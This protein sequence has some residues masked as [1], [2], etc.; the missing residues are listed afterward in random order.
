MI[1]IDE[2]PRI[3]TTPINQPASD[4]V[5]FTEW[6]TLINNMARI[7]LNQLQAY[8]L[9]RRFDKKYLVTEKALLSILAETISSYSVL[10]VEKS[11][12]NP[13]ITTYYDSPDFKF[14]RQ[15]HSG[16]RKRVK[17]RTRTYLSS[18][19]S[20]LE[21]KRKGFSNQVVKE[22][23]SIESADLSKCDCLSA[24]FDQYFPLPEEMLEAKLNNHFIRITLANRFL[25]ERV[26]IDLGLTFFNEH[27]KIALPG[28]AVL[29][30]KQENQHTK[31]ALV[32]ALH[33]AHLNPQNFS[34]Y[35]IG[36]A[37]LETQV[38]HNHFKKNLIRLQK[39]MPERNYFYGIA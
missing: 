16:M 11:C 2:L 17:V 3:N 21:I 13:Y 26:T 15:H 5:R 19:Q 33:R 9:M 20:F 34:K 25:I 12:L 29:E 38:K 7:D 1:M 36:I 8:A 28:V 10:E 22:R 6:E 37:L 14:Y 27:K 23:I 32:N 35:C 4:L 24:F 30:I 39:L 31:T 18:D